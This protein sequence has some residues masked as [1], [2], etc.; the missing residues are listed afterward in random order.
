MRSPDH[1]LPD[2]TLFL[3]VFKKKFPSRYFGFTGINE[4]PAGRYFGLTE[5]LTVG[6]AGFLELMG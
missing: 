3:T 5:F 6:K 4:R 1:E 2:T